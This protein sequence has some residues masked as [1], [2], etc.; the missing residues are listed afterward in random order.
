MEGG[1]IYGKSAD[2]SLA[3]IAID[4]YAALKVSDASVAKWGT[5][6]G[7]YTKGVESQTGGSVIDSTDETLIAIPAN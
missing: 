2:A 6:G 1:R 5:G 7:A 3:N 4:G